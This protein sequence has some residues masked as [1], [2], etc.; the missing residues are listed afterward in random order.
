MFVISSHA[1]VPGWAFFC[2]I[3]LVLDG[4]EYIGLLFVPFGRHS[5]PKTMVLDSP[6]STNKTADQRC[7]FGTNTLL[8]ILHSDSATEQI[9]GSMRILGIP[10]QHHRTNSVMTFIDVYQRKKKPY[11]KCKITWWLGRF[12]A[13]IGLLSVSQM[14]YK[15]YIVLKRVILSW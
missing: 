3:L 11:W 10:S 5:P 13:L 4:L 14:W 2:S 1:V 7:V 9:M 12:E 8:F 6:N 15:T